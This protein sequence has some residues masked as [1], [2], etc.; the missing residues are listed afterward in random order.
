MS[1]CCSNPSAEGCDVKTDAARAL[2]WVRLGFAAL[3]AGQTMTFSLGINDSPPQGME[4]TI[5]HSILAGSALLVFLLI[6]LPLAAEAW[7]QLRAGRIVIEQMFLLG[8]AGAY[9]A[10]LHSSL[11]GEGA[12]YYEVVAILLA[13]YTLGTLVSRNRREAALESSESLRRQYDRCFRLNNEGVASECA[14]EDVRPGDQIV[15][16]PGSGIPVDGRI[17]EGTAFIRETAMTGEP[18]PVVR[19]AGDPV[20]AGSVVL[21][22]KL[23]I[24]AAS[25]GKSRK[26]DLL[27]ARIDQARQLPSSIQ[28]EADRLITWFLPSVLFISIA[29]FIGW[30]LARGWVVGLFNGLAV[31]VV[32]CPCAMGMATPI[33]IMSALN[34]F[35]RRGLVA[36][37]GDL[38]EAL[39]RINTVVFDKTGT[40]S[41]D[42]LQLVE[43]AVEPGFEREKLRRWI[44]AIQAGSAHPIA[45]AFKDWAPGIPAGI[46]AKKIE[47]I[48]GAGVRGVVMEKS[49]SYRLAIGNISVLAQKE[50]RPSKLLKNLRA[51]GGSLMEIHVTV[52]G[53]AAAVALLRE[54]LRAGSKKIMEE[55]RGMDLRVEVMSGDRMERLEELG[56]QGA[57]A[58]LTPEEK[59]RLVEDME[60]V[61]KRV[62]FVGD[63]VND[64]AAMSCATTS[65][66]LASGADLTREVA[67]GQL[68]GSDLRAIPWARRQAVRV[69]R[70]IRQNLW[71]SIFYNVIG[72]SLAASG[73]LHP[74]AAAVL[75]LVSSVTVTWRALRFGERLQEEADGA[76]ETE[77][78]E[79][80]ASLF[81]RLSN[82]GGLIWNELVERISVT[83]LILG[84]AMTAQGLSISYL[85]A[86]RFKW[87]LTTDLL[88]LGAGI[89]LV[90]A[91]KS[92]A[93]RP[94]WVL[95]AGML[96]VGNLG[97]LAG[98]YADSGFVPVVRD[99]F[100]SSCCA[101]PHAAFGL[102]LHWNWM[103]TGMVLASIP[104]LFG[105][106]VSPRRVRRKFFNHPWLHAV[107][108]LGG[109]LV[110]M[111][112]SG[113]VMNW[114]A[115]ADP[116]RHY[117][118]MLASMTAGMFIGM[119][120]FCQAYFRWLL[121]QNEECRIQKAELRHRTPR[122]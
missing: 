82:I 66:A 42:T 6:G 84:L 97:M 38:I 17:A 69:M 45:R 10:S 106:D 33:G 35:A 43:F 95:Y 113:I 3:I 56:L 77:V 73:T 111:Q 26:L 91:A 51:K 92:W 120:L 74:V 47:V 85:G 20:L 88:F 11:T 24:E 21:D 70:G 32:A 55:L 105:I 28:K 68:F 64:S 7:R 118:L 75:M 22:E 4:R 87:A 71:I 86:L 81:T 14:V 37:S 30:T 2:G 44:G 40:L 36:C 34:A 119:I 27:L 115:V 63:G 39:A 41:E 62:L 104:L 19:K 76:E 67:D 96:A 46:K 109:M 89:F 60:A 98:W 1:S 110:G 25:S 107:F 112:A 54:N 114:V 90:F 5:L 13:I 122:T 29:T 121:G 103:Q 94:V 93:R 12:I 61:G 83:G 116:V 53:K 65:I 23:V 48:P 18:F 59:R 52:D 8:I 79:N 57:R 102:S 99:G 108:C 78:G 16:Y 31:L 100:C 117:L 72:I 58:D 49:I 101:G 15:V 50:A 80:G 9:G